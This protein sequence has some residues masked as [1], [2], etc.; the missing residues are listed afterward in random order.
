MKNLADTKW[1]TTRPAREVDPA[2]RE[3]ILAL[4]D[5]QLSV[6]D[7]KAHLDAEGTFTLAERAIQRVLQAAGRGRLPRRTRAQRAAAP[8]ERAPTSACLDPAH[9]EAFQGERAA[10]ILCLL[11]WLRHYEFDK[12]IAA[13]GYPGSSELPAL[14][15][16]LS[17][18]ALKLSHVRRYSTD[19]MWCMDRSLGLFAGLNVLP[20][21]AWLSSY[22]DRPRAP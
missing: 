11:P 19:D 21:T 2:L 22:S 7:I 5:L 18:L 12:L 15:A 1:N 6:P 20:K 13:A 14:Q 16:V 4:R 10:G 8:A 17:V 9:H 3:R